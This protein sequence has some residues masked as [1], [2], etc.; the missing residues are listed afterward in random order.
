M[1]KSRLRQ[2]LVT[3]KPS[4]Y[5]VPRLP[6]A[7]ARCGLVSPARGDQEIGIV[8]VSM[9][10]TMSTR[11]RSTAMPAVRVD[12]LRAPPAPDAPLPTVTAPPRWVRLAYCSLSA[13][14]VGPLGEPE[15]VRCARTVRRRLC[16]GPSRGRSIRSAAVRLPSRKVRGPAGDEVRARPSA[17]VSYTS[18]VR[19]RRPRA[20]PWLTCHCP[21][22]L[23]PGL[24]ARDCHCTAD[25]Q[26][27]HFRCQV[28]RSGWPAVDSRGARGRAMIPRASYPLGWSASAG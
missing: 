1:Q 14:S 28:A 3:M 7:A 6:P 12:R 19:S 17:T 5:R 22:G 13:V 18:A 27:G 11:R 26:P 23:G 4:A 10:A 9:R 24:I 2:L 15:G 25:N 20:A 8:S 16:S 21:D